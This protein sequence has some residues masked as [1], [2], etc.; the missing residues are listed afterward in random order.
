MSELLNEKSSVTIAIP[1]F[2]AEKYLSQAIDSIIFQTYCDWELLLVD[3]GSTDSSVSIAEEYQK[4]DD[5]IKLYTDG[6]NKNLGF[7]LNEI[8][9]LVT[10]EYLVRMD[11]DD[12]M[13]P[14]KIEKQLDALLHY[15]EIDVLG[16]NAYSIDE[17]NNVVGIRLNISKEEIIP[18]ETFIHPTIMA[19]TSWFLSNPYDVTAVRVE[20]IELWIRSKDKSKFY[21]LTEPL[22]FYREFGGGYYKKYLKSLPSFWNLVMKNN[23]KK[24]YLLLFIKN[25]IG[26]IVYFVY[27]KLGKEHYLILKRNQKILKPIS[28]KQ[29]I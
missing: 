18:V 27:D 12:I 28:Y 7:R 29:Y 25:I 24:V 1:F 3:D 17:D 2:N 8:P 22:F 5:R 4:K 13:H 11:A 10:T 14:K 26:T 21:I 16:T 15:P 9:K 20:D 6:E 23:F 19:R